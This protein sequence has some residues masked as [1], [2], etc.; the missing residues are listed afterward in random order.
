M[1]DESGKWL[2]VNVTDVSLKELMDRF[3]KLARTEISDVI[4]RHGPMREVIEEE[5]RRLSSR[6]S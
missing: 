5:L 3:P 2:R 6:K 1:N 4:S